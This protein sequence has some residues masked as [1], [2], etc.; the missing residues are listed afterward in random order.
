MYNEKINPF[1]LPEGEIRPSLP[2]RFQIGD[3]VSLSFNNSG[4]VENCKVLKVHFSERREFYD[5]EVTCKYAEYPLSEF[6]GD[7][8]KV[9]LHNIESA[10]LVEADSP[11][12]PSMPEKGDVYMCKKSFKIQSGNS[13]TFTCYEINETYTFGK[14]DIARI[15]TQAV[16]DD[17]F[18]LY[19][20]V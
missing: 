18:D 15:N 11:N 2:S 12:M 13:N 4:K 7:E 10:V 16:F 5:V 1:G 14:S 9:R 17:H 6:N 19:A 20:I 8:Y 3:Y